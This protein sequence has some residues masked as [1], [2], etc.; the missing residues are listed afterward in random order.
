ML[1]FDLFSRIISIDNGTGK[2]SK[3]EP[4][5]PDVRIRKANVPFHNVNEK[6][7]MYL[8]FFFAFIQTLM[9]AYTTTGFVDGDY[10]FYYS[11]WGNTMTMVVLWLLAFSHKHNHET[12]HDFTITM[13]ELALT[14]EYVINPLYW[15]LLYEPENFDPS[16]F[17]SYRGPYM[18]HFA[19]FLLLNIEWWMNG[20]H[21]NCPKT[22]KYI[23]Y[24]SPFYL[25]LNY[26]G[27]IIMGKPMYFFLNF[28]NYKSVII[29][30]NI[31]IL[32]IFIYIALSWINNFVKSKHFTMLK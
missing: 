2:V 30:L 14:M 26:C 29:C 4:L 3:E 10:V 19:P 15:T 12:F 9:W 28:E 13:F 21:W 1:R 16:S 25:T 20:F 11:N 24:F 6:A 17:V 8:R 7:V 23:A 27:T 31:L 5:V 18:N 22:I 32:K